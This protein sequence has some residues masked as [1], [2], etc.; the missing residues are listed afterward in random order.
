MKKL[1]AV[2]VSLASVICLVS[3]GNIRS[4][5]D[6]FEDGYDDG[7]S[8]A[9]LKMEKK[10]SYWYDEGYWEGSREGWIDYLEKPGRYLEEEAVHYA[11]EYSQWHPEEAMA[12]IQSYQ[13]KEPLDGAIPTYEEYI[14]A[15]ES[16]LRFYE[17][18]YC[19]MYK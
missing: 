5:D 18:F 11:R 4:Y 15:I 2:L 16:L 12:I 1:I 14:D 6:G 13:N 3:C 17:Y 19:A 7:Y 9:V 10:F 8:D